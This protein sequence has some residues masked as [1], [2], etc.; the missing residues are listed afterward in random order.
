MTIIKK[1]VS[2]DFDIDMKT[3]INYT[4]SSNVTSF[5]KFYQLI[6]K[7]SPSVNKILDDLDR[8]VKNEI[9]NFKT[10]ERICKQ[11]SISIDELTPTEM[12]S[13]SKIITQNSKDFKKDKTIYDY[14]YKKIVK[15]KISL[16]S[17]IRLIKDIIFSMVD[18]KRKYEYI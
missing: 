16:E 6:N 4:I 3:V 8:N 18:L 9:V 7:I 10:L 12:K 5:R 15:K 11:Y 13:I 2:D 14:K 17:K 1:D